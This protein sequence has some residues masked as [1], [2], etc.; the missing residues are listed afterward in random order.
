VLSGPSEVGKGKPVELLFRLTNRTERPLYVLKWHTPL[1]GFRA[2]FL[3]VTRDGAG[4][5]Y[6]GPMMKRGAPAKDDYAT[7]APGASVEARI[8]VSQAYD[9]SGPASYQFAFRDELM[10]V[11]TEQAEVPHAL[12]GFQAMEVECPSVETTRTE[13]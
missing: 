1:E 11:A 2:D 5:P 10:D 9:V 4:V 13:S 3:I 6:K 7:L 12:D 8:D